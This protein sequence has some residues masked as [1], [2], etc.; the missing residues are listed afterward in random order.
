VI[1]PDAAINMA[2]GAIVDGVGNALFGEMIFQD[3]V[4]QKNNFNTY[5]IIRH[6]EAPKSIEIHFVKSETD[7]TGLGEPPFPPVFA[8]V[9]NALFKATGKRFYQQPFI[10]D[11]QAA[12]LMV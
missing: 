9:A 2:E 4:P 12:G 7:P 5:R 1:N 10:K 6:N 3:G 11:I 8:A